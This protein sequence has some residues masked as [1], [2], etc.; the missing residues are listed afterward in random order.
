MGGACR[1][2]REV[3]VQMSKLSLCSREAEGGRWE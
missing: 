2:G 3:D 1:L